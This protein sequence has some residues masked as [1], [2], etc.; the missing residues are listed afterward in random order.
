MAV[1][2]PDDL[3]VPEDDGAAGHLQGTEM[4]DVSLPVTD[5]TTVN[6]QDLPRRTVIYVYPLTERPDRT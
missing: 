4:P 2:L 1:P 6:L 3:P 5:G